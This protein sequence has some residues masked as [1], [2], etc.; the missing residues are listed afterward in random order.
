MTRTI[1]RTP[2]VCTEERVGCV[3]AVSNSRTVPVQVL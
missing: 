1:E 2:A 3:A